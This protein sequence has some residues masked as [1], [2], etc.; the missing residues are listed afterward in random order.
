[1]LRI[2]LLALLLALGGTK[3]FVAHA[4][5]TFKITQGGRTLVGNNEDAWS[6]NAQVRFEQGKNG[7]HGAIYFGHYNGLPFRPMVD[8]VGMNEA[9]LVFDGL[10]IQPK[11]VAPTPGV[12]YVPFQT[13]MPRVMRTCSTVHE[14]AALLREH[15]LSWLTRSM[16][17]LVDRNGEYLI[18]EA[19]TM[20]FGNDPSIALGNWRMSSCSDPNAI[21]IPRLQ[22][23]R[24][25]LAEGIDTTMN[26]ARDVLHHMRACRAK[27]G[28]GTLFSTLFD[29]QRATARLYFYHD[30]DHVVEFDLQR[31]L[32]R[33][34]RT[35]AMVDFF[36]PNMEY[37]RL[38]AY[39]TPFHERWLFWTLTLV[40]ALFLVWIPIGGL[41][42]LARLIKR[43]R[44]KDGKP[45]LPL[46]LTVLISV[47]FVPLIGVLLT[48]EGVYY[49]G[50]ADAAPALAWVPIMLI[51]L[52]LLLGWSM[53]RGIRPVLI[54]GSFLLLPLFAL[55]GYWG[56]LL[57]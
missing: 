54:I 45:I 8:Q 9:G 55:L 24:A 28:E 53:R 22:A 33:G 3:P 44:S 39:I 57:P 30:F 50:L 1:M 25:L 26:A 46:L 40:G 18:V 4:C 31:E 27:M 19:D 36:P 15:D 34:D 10:G 2:I 43:L 51:A 21:P 12:L 42:L 5:T 32:A 20:M 17:F 11:Q 52:A 38:E 37:Q 6:T 29:T 35:L 49:F 56:M 48:N 14:A 16:L 13:L 7:E 23:G 47:L 41:L